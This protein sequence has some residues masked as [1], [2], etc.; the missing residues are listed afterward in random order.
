MA[1][2]VLPTPAS[3]FA[4]II[5]RVVSFTS[6]TSSTRLY[7]VPPPSADDKVATKTYSDREKPPS[8]FYELQINCARAAKLAMADGHQLLEIEVGFD[9][10]VFLTVL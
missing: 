8:S 2:I 6:F 5:P 1:V 3:S 4:S 9:T 7:N 10:S